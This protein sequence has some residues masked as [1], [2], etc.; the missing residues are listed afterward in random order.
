MLRRGLSPGG[1]RTKSESGWR[2]MVRKA[3]AVG[4]A[5]GSIRVSYIDDEKRAK[6]ETSVLSVTSRRPGFWSKLLAGWK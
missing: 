1:L 5:N 3:I 6:G 2:R 4:S